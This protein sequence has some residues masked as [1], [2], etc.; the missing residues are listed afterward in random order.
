MFRKKKKILVLEDEKALLKA[1]CIKLENDGYVTIP[2]E[3]GEDAV[4]AIEKRIFNLAILDLLVPRV[5]GFSVLRHLRERDTEIAI[6][7][8]SNLSQ[9]EDIKRALDI[10][11]D[12][13]FIKSNISLD[14]IANE[15][16]KILE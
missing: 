13:Y 2:C 4:K 11:A 14:D 16:K 10:G 12:K 15:A 8:V 7:I 5:D 6:F 3:N 1:L 9:K